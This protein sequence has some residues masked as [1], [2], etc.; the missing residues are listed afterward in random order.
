MSLLGSEIAGSSGL[1]GRSPSRSRRKKQGV[2]EKC[3]PLLIHPSSTVRRCA[4]SL[5]CMSS[6]VLGVVDSELIAQLLTPYLQYKPTF[7]SIPHLLACAKSPSIRKTSVILRLFEN[8]QA[9]FEISTKLAKSLS[10]PSQIS[11]ELVAKSDYNWYVDI[12]RHF[13][14]TAVPFVIDCTSCPS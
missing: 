7:E 13:C 8:F 6:R 3:G 4:A 1:S 12:P 5:V 2:I 10:V 9:D 14:N 11:V